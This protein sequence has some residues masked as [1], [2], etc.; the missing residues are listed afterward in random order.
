L[1]STALIL[2]LKLFNVSISI[3]Y[4]DYS[5]WCDHTLSKEMFSNATTMMYAIAVLHDG[6]ARKQSNFFK[7]FPQEQWSVYHLANLIT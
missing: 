6:S 1:K 4:A 2:R 7:E 3:Q 5:P